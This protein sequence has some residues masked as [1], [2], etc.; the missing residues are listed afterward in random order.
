MIAWLS[1][2]AVKG[3][4]DAV[5]LSYVTV[6]GAIFATLSVLTLAAGLFVIIRAAM[7]KEQLTQLRS[8]RDDLIV[9]R[10]LQD[11]EILRVVAERD[12]ERGRR[13]ALELV[14]TSK[15]EIGDVMVQ[16]KK[17]DERAERIEKK[18]T[19]IDRNTRPTRQR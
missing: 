10:D 2:T 16:L 3:V 13:E 12:A 19:E 8:V 6:P 4:T 17:H 18:V 14:V 11:K 9:E 7:A 5:S 15:K 1:F